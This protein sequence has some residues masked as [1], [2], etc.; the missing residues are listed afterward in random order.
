MIDPTYGE[1]PSDF[2]KTVLRHQNFLARFN[3]AFVNSYTPSLRE[4]HSRTKK[5]AATT[6]K[7]G[8]VVMVHDEKPRNLWKMAVVES[9]ITNVDDLQ[10]AVPIRDGQV[11][12]FACYIRL[13]YP[14]KPTHKRI[15]RDRQMIQTAHLRDQA[16]RV[17]RPDQNAEQ[18]RRRKTES[19]GSPKSNFR[20]PAVCQTKS[21]QIC[22]FSNFFL[23]NYFKVATMSSCL[24]PLWRSGSV[25]R[26]EAGVHLAHEGF[27][28]QLSSLQKTN[29]T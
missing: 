17:P 21:F 10:P 18:Q 24:P 7:T 13:G 3:K 1:S 29:T 11:D 27:R 15:Q 28:D 14:Y 4:Y 12:Q 9:L 19:V 6:I 20:R 25:T 8:E 5:N 22:Q 23:Q 16:S 26:E 2:K